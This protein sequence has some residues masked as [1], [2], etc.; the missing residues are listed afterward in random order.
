[1]F[2]AILSA[3]LIEIRKGL[4]EDL[5]L[6][7]LD[8]LQ[9]ATTQQSFQPTPI[10]IWVNGLWFSSLAASLAGAVVVMLAKSLSRW[11]V[12][13]KEA[14]P[15]FSKP[16]GLQRRLMEIRRFYAHAIF[17]YEL[18]LLLRTASMLIYLALALFFAGLVVLLYTTQR[19]IGI[20]FVTMTSLMGLLVLCVVFHNSY[21]YGK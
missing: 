11:T 9:R 8:E 13:P 20:S 15:I 14:Y 3:F 19:G 4:Q 2:S 16:E 12:S 10:S 6:L 21:S 1:L 7:I 18:A 5:L 17:Q